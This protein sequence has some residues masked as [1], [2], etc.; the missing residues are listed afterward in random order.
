[1][2]MIKSR[3][4]KIYEKHQMRKYY[5]IV[6]IP[7]IILKGKWLEKLGFKIGLMVNI[8]QMENKLI[9]TLDR[10]GKY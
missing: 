1:M 3:R 4:L 10:E 8:E 5:K 2:K 9:I 6:T 7:E